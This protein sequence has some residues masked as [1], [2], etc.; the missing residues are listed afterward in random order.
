MSTF[1]KEYIMKVVLEESKYDVPILSEEHAAFC[2]AEAERRYAGRI[3]RDG[4]MLLVKDV[5]GLCHTDKVLRAL[6]FFRD[7]EDAA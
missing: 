7:S 4:E 5:K 2:R 1:Q 6:S 3:I